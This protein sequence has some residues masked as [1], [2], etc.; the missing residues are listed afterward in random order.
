MPPKIAY[1]VMKYP[2]LT[3]T[4]IEREMLGLAAQDLEIEV[5]PC[6]DFRRPGAGEPE[7]PAALPVVRAGSAGRFFLAVCVG[8]VRE[9]RRRPGLVRR[10][11][12][13]L[14]RYPPQNWES[15]FM[16]V[17]GTLFALARAAEF[18]R[19]GIAVI[20]GAWATAPA[21][22]AAVLSEL[23]GIPY[24]FGAHAYDLHRYGG[25]P[26]LSP[27]LRTA[28]FVH[29]TTRANAE[30]LATRFPS[31]RA[32]IVLA[33]RGLG[34]LPALRAAKGSAFD[35]DGANQKTR[36]QILSVGR[37]VEKKCHACQIEACIE[38]ARRG[39]PFH[40]R[41][42]GEGPL[43]P[44][45]AA[46]IARAKLQHRVELA[47]ERSPAEVAAAYA[48]ADVFWHTGVVDSRGDRDGLPN[49]IP[50]A[51][52]HGLA[53]ISSAV[54]GAGEAIQDGE[55]GLIV[56]PYDPAALADA[57]ISLAA[58]PAWRQQLGQ[59]GRRWVER[60]FLAEENTRQLAQAFRAAAAVG[61]S[62]AA[63]R[64]TR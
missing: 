11:W 5:H 22:A 55:N 43:R 35:S 47:G 14:Q 57:V 37:L 9:L 7:T 8:A 58:D 3:Q 16:T 60:N 46:S 63:G 36:L 21:T 12:R 30:L 53:V 33:R 24:S 29:T 41:I 25:D 15:W 34:K 32:E 10:A 51:L 40:L 20:H 27:K 28:R 26:L 61:S 44:E 54:G 45:L 49:V 48:A 18:R 1:I 62:E 56:D 38:L 39:L 23:C 52:A 13:V 50:E 19:R 4:F 2:T 6:F 31:R 64:A 59:E 42:I 17:C